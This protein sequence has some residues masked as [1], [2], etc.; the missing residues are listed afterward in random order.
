MTSSSRKEMLF[1]TSLSPHP[2]S[3]TSSC[4][5]T[6]TTVTLV[7]LSLSASVTSLYSKPI[8]IG[9]LFPLDTKRPF[10][11]DKMRPALDLAIEKVSLY[12]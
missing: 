11:I 2:T 3:M 1:P 10:S 5:I 7:I 4:H 6:M 8:K 9:A 12:R